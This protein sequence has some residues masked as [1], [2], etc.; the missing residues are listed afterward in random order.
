[1]LLEKTMEVHT[2]TQGQLKQIA[3]K[4]G[5]LKGQVDDEALN[6]KIEKAQRIIY[7][8]QEIKERDLKAFLEN[9][10]KLQ[11]ENDVRSLDGIERIQRPKLKSGAS[12]V[13]K[14]MFSK[15]L[16]AAN[17]FLQSFHTHLGQKGVGDK[18]IQ[19]PCQGRQQLVKSV[20][21][22]QMIN[23]AD[24]DIEFILE[25]KKNEESR[26]IRKEGGSGGL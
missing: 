25:D 1:M 7:E 19:T 4:M 20:L 12:V 14:T 21:A 3:D 17:Y 8:E 18:A 10:V 15:D 5:E 26:I 9:T 11:Q 6:Q 2:Q 22:D 23:H 24:K 13:K 16:T